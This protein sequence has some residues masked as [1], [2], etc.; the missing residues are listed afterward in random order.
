MSD[1]FQ[2]GDIVTRRGDD[3][4]RIL[5]ISSCGDSM[6]VECIR[7]DKGSVVDDDGTLSDPCYKI[8]DQE[9][10]LPRR[11]SYPEFM[12]IEGEAAH[13]QTYDITD[14]S[15][16]R[17]LPTLRPAALKPYQEAFIREL[18][19]STATTKQVTVMKRLNIGHD[20]FAAEIRA[21]EIMNVLPVVSMVEF[22]DVYGTGDGA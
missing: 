14:A 4:H 13:R 18:L 6:L 22:K 19:D 20:P 5:Q 9:W 3:L 2:V 10:N 15:K 17:M 21:H 11:Y 1:L 16:T 7:P 12:T 8:G